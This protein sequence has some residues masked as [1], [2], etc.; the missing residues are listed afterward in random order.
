M[1]DVY[2]CYLLLTITMSMQ[3]INNQSIDK[4]DRMV[5]TWAKGK[6]SILQERKPSGETWFTSWLYTL[7][8]QWMYIKHDRN[9]VF[10][11]QSCK[12]MFCHSLAHTQR[13]N[14]TVLWEEKLIFKEVLVLVSERGRH[15]FPIFKECILCFGKMFEADIQCMFGGP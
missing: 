10:F 13:V 14:M 1:L 4:K 6:H 12:E 8:E 2:K 7:T 9:I 15:Y 11:P 5:F 3:I